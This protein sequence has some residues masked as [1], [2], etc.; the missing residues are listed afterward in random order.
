MF[1]R[2]AIYYAPALDDPLWKKGTEW[3]GA[4]PADANARFPATDVAGIARDLIDANSMS[5]RRYGFHATLKA[6]MALAD[7]VTRD[8]LEAALSAF[9]T[10][11]AAVSI[12][13]LK[14]AAIGAFLALIPEAHTEALTKLVG[15]VVAAFDGLRAPMDGAERARRTKGDGLSARQLELLDRFGYPYVLEEFRFHMTL[16]DRLDDALREK[17][18]AAIQTH[19]GPVLEREVAL[20]RLVVYGEP[21]EGGP[22]ARLGEYMLTGSET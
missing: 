18:L 5:A 2:Y 1:K 8:E 12:G 7:G 13:R 22:F 16:T 15:D 21:R 19:F 6:P 11:T 17:M 10:R 3:L 9:A 20:D 14:P 4:N